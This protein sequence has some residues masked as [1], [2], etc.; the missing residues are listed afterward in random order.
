MQVSTKRVDLQE[1]GELLMQENEL[2]RG[3]IDELK[4]EIEELKKSRKNWIRRC[5]KL[6]LGI[7]PHAKTMNRLLGNFGSPKDE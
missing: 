7:R 5:E 4:A 6:E 2:L 3:H 1:E